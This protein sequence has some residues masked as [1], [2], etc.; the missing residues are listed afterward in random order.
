MAMEFSPKK[1]WK[2]DV[3]IDDVVRELLSTQ[4]GGRVVGSAGPLLICAQGPVGR[5]VRKLSASSTDVSLPKMAKGRGE[6]MKMDRALIIG[7]CVLACLAAETQAQPSGVTREEFVNTRLRW[8][9]NNPN[10]NP[11]RE[12]LERRFD[13]LDTDEDG[14]LS[15][16]ELAADRPLSRGMTR[17][18]FIRT[19]LQWA[20]EHP[21]WNPSQ[22]ELSRRFDELDADGDGFLSVDELA[23][24]HA[25]PTARGISREQ[26]V[27]ERLRWAENNPRWNPTREDLEARF[28]ELDVNRDGFLSDQELAAENVREEPV[29][30]AGHG[31]GITRQQYVNQRLQWAR[32]DP[33]W[34]PTREDLER[35]FDELDTDGDGFLSEAEIEAGRGRRQPAAHQ[36]QTQVRETQPQARGLT[37]NQYVRQRLQWARNNPSWN[38]TRE[39]LERRFDELDTDGDGILTE[40]EMEAGR[41][42]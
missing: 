18:E 11:T 7:M 41:R 4:A 6:M 35:R 36:P 26:Y 17:D 40:A 10:W 32:N 16:A 15:E 12:Q 28:D 20:R 33:R 21:Q 23:V 37:K 27:S 38:P 9:E 34:N 19:R 42:R 13:Q 25:Q 39:D 31:L 3:E 1:N 5:I 30:S 24:E 29:Q 22:A 8:A 14:L 2:P